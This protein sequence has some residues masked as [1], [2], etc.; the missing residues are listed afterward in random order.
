MSE[1]DKLHDVRA[2][3]EDSPP[4]GARMRDVAEAAGVSVATVSNV[5]N[6]PN[7]V[8]L[9]TRERVQSVIQALDFQPDPHAKALRGLVASIPEP[10]SRREPDPIPGGN[11]MHIDTPRNDV[12][13]ACSA[14][15]NS[16]LNHE[17]LIPGNH[18]SLRVGPEVL[19][20]IVDAVMPDK[21]CF[22]V[23]T[24]GGMGRRMIA[25]SDAVAVPIAGCPSP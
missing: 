10:S 3:P 4:S 1:F 16:G 17:I 2:K 11:E 23:W 12:A 24:D 15:A 7:L 22:W 9:R 6:H 13:D 8:A 25:S 19:S 21:S 14:P 20:G 18:L 5:V